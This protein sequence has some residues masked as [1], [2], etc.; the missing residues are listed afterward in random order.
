MFAGK[1]LAGGLLLVLGRKLFW[2]YVALLGFATGLTV[3]SRL[4]NVQ[5]EWMQLV[6]GIGMGILGAALAYYFQEFAVAVAGFFGG[7]Y[8]ATGLLALFPYTPS[9]SGDV[10][11]WILFIVGGVIGAILAIML[12][13]WALIILT[14]VAGALLMVEGLSLTAPWA[15][16][17]AI[18]LSMIG[19]IIQAGLQRLPQKQDDITRPIHSHR[20]S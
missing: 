10:V 16:L 8:V 5:P 18:G 12:F 15:G 3:A 7:A 4:F 9:P 6:I 20:S 11:T 19:V 14:S 1:I 13:D 17:I 2:L